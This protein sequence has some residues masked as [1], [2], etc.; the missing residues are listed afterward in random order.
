MSYI[1]RRA[2]S[3]A[4]A[5]LLAA[6]LAPHTAAQSKPPVAPPQIVIT[7]VTIINPGTSSVAPDA[8]VVIEGAR[9]TAVSTGAAPSVKPAKD[10]RVIDATGH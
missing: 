6:C 1:S 2:L 9:I 5:L 10:A 7:H 4:A 8:T 3:V